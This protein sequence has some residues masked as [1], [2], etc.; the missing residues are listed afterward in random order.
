MVRLT[1]HAKG[2]I[3]AERLSLLYRISQTIN[4][5][6]DLDRVMEVLMD[7]VISATNAERGFLMIL[8]ENERLQF[9]TA[10]GMDQK[11]LETSEFRI[12]RSIAERVA[13]DGISL[14][15]SNAQVDKRFDNRASVRLY[16]L[17]SVVSVPIKLK[18]KILG[19]IYIDNHFQNGIFSQEDLDL[20]N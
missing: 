3:S 18:D 19:V 15:T 8:G 17:R 16:G 14:L 10:R 5:S 13:R 6:L 9:R 2:L 4:S 12:S 20:L 1:E 7:E 11:T